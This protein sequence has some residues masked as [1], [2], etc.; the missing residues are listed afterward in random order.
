MLDKCKQRLTMVIEI[1]SCETKKWMQKI[2]AYRKM[3]ISENIERDWGFCFCMQQSIISFFLSFFLLF[4][5]F[6]FFIA[7]ASVLC[8]NRDAAMRWLHSSLIMIML[9]MRDNWE[10]VGLSNENATR[11]WTKRRFRPR[12]FCANLSP[13]WCVPPLTRS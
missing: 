3:R 2:Y 12:L 8:E 6:F 9:L 10:K 11:G 1:E 5:F 7:F 4:F 13:S